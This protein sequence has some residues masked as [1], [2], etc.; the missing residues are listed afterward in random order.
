MEQPRQYLI[1]ALMLICTSL[2][3]QEP[4]LLQMYLDWQ[5]GTAK[6]Y[7]SVGST[8]ISMND[9]LITD[10]NVE[11]IFTLTVIDTTDRF[12][13]EFKDRSLDLSIEMD[14]MLDPDQRVEDVI[15]TFS[16]TI[17]REMQDFVYVIEVDK[18]VALA[19]KILNEQEV[20]E[21][22]H[23]SLDRFTEELGNKY[24][25]GDQKIDSLH[26][27]IEVKFEQQAPL[28]TQTILNTL[29][30]MFQTYSYAFDPEGELE[31]GIMVYD[32]NAMSE[33]GTDEFPAVLKINSKMTEDELK[34]DVSTVYDQEF[35]WARFQA[36]KGGLEDISP[37]DLNISEINIVTF[38]LNTTW[39]TSFN[40]RIEFLLK[41]VHV[42]EQKEMTIIE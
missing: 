2:L 3:G 19:T 17:Q 1:G 6:T 20:L 7:R 33:F 26:S 37:N 28:M 39:I 31:Q 4:E 32:V 22:L 18:E 35:L 14:P 34:L 30:Y 25:I 42:L 16:R 38:D 5:L 41:G 23:L 36:V 21:V 27:A 12:V 11:Q 15:A 9:T 8:K 24:G 40:T 29:N 10:A 13:L